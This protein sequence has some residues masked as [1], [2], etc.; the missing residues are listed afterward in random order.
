MSAPR[1]RPMRAA[2][3]AAVAAIYAEGIADR[4]ATFETQAPPAAAVAGWVEAFPVVVVED[5]DG[6]VLGW[7]SAPP[8]RPQRDAYAGVREC[9]VYVARAARGGGV[10][11]VALTGLIETC[12]AAGH[13]KLLS[14]IFPENRVSLAMC[15]SV[16][17]REVG[18]Y[19]RHARLDGQWRD[20]VIVELLIDDLPPAPMPTA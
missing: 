5:G 4:V 19:L 3:A 12:R 18:T 11:R 1:W 14:R 15:R 10:G 6:A 16:G 2:D 20:C 13:W 7:A 9:S 17:F 8:Y